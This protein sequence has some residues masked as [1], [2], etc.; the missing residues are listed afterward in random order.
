MKD[1]FQSVRNIYFVMYTFRKKLKI[2][3]KYFLQ[4]GFEKKK[5][6]QKIMKRLIIIRKETS[7][8]A[9][10][11]YIVF[12]TYAMNKIKIEYD[13]ATRFRLR[14]GPFY[15]WK[16]FGEIIIKNLQI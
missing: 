4:I 6:L 5:F 1:F 7:K 11:M 9:A 15:S 16:N 2:D 8:G 13:G 3:L 12:R 14:N 10:R